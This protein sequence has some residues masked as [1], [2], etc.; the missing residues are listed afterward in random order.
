MNS[1]DLLT[2]VLDQLQL[3]YSLQNDESIRFRWYRVRYQKFDFDIAVDKKWKLLMV[4]YFGFDRV[5]NND[6]D[7]LLKI[8]QVIDDINFVMPAKLVLSGTDRDYA[9][10]HAIQ[11]L[12]WIPEIPDLGKHLKKSFSMLMNIIDYYFE[13]KE[14]IMSFTQTTTEC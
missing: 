12:F 3:K 7:N 10:V 13:K 11:D 4:I 9:E 8:H 5:P 2:S 6:A 1:I 14:E